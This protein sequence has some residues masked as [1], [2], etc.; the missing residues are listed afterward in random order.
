M[1]IDKKIQQAIQAYMQSKQFGIAQTPFHTHNG[2]DSPKLTTSSS[3]ITSI[4]GDTTTA[5]VISGGTDISAS[6]SGGTTTIAFT[7]SIPTVPTSYSYV[8]SIYSS[9][10]GRTSTQ[11]VDTTYTTA[12]TPTTITIYYVLE[13]A[14]GTNGGAPITY[15]GIAIFSGTTLTSNMLTL[16]NKNG[17]LTTTNPITFSTSTPTA[18]NGGASYDSTEVFVQSVSSTN[19]VIRTAFVKGSVFNGLCSCQYTAIAIA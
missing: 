17:T 3:G 15:S 5:Q 2:I 18:G 11:N 7:G 9:T 8:T 6:T 16:T 1:D 4:N 10:A 19:F 12:F 13:G 14:D